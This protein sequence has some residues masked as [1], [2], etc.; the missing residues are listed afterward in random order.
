MPGG[1]GPSP[2]RALRATRIAR[3]CGRLARREE[4]AAACD[5]NAGLI[6][7]NPEIVSLEAPVGSSPLHDSQVVHEAEPELEAGN[8]DGEQ[9]GRGEALPRDS[10]QA[11]RGG[12]PLCTQVLPEVGGALRDRR[13]PQPAQSRRSRDG[14]VVRGRT[15]D[16]VFNFNRTHPSASG[17]RH[18]HTAAP[19]SSGSSKSNGTAGG[20]NGDK[21]DYTPE[22]HSVVKRVRACKVTEYY[23]I[24][25]LKKDCEE[26][27]IKKAYRKVSSTHE[28]SCK[29]D[30]LVSLPW[31][32]ILTRMAHPALMRRSRVCYISVCYRSS[33]YRVLSGIEGIPSTLR[34]V[35][36]LRRRT[37]RNGNGMAFESELSPEDLFNMFFVFTASF[38]PGGFRTTGGR[39]HRHQHAQPNNERAE[40]RNKRKR[41]KKG[42]DRVVDPK[43]TPENRAVR[44]AIKA[45]MRR[46]QRVKSILVLHYHVIAIRSIRRAHLLGGPLRP[47]STHRGAQG[48]EKRR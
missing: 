18:R 2:H 6:P 35:G 38:G 13:R 44:R 48:A 20:M 21:R 23:E 34:Q 17:A 27:E 47:M 46:Q 12:I 26:A 16:I 3:R 39:A 11:Q 28:L 24:L 45:A 25:D 29:T 19:S 7:G 14:L 37:I 41:R 5:V 1:T 42:E 9:Q 31:L 10:P 36:S 32:C 8:K 40:P 4:R 22:Q 30:G 43:N 33:A 15:H